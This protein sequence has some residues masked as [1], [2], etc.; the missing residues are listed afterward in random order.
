MAR[1]EA[2]SPRLR[3]PLCRPPTRHLAALM[4]RAVPV[5]KFLERI[6]YPRWPT[7]LEAT[8]RVVGIIVILLNITVVF[9]PIPLSSVVPGL[10][11]ALISLAY[12]EEDRLLLLIGLS[13]AVV[14]L[15][16]AFAAVWE[17]V[18]GAEWIGRLL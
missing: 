2:P 7:P 3:R 14:V 18:V 16:I 15:T 1:D 17:M 13:A 6:T 11:I 9:S 5:L 10:V 4:Q 12:L 8:K